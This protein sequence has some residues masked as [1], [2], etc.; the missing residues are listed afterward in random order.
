MS[1]TRVTTRNLKWSTRIHW[2]HKGPPMTNINQSSGTPSMSR[3]RVP[4]DRVQKDLKKVFNKECNEDKYFLIGS[5]I[6]KEEKEQMVKFL[7]DNVDV[8]AW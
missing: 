7:K 8:F 3:L 4:K 5:S 6:R 2:P 1:P